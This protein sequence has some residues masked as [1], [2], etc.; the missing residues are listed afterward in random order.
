MPK[1]AAATA[2]LITLDAPRPIDEIGGASERQAFHKRRSLSVPRLMLGEWLHIFPDGLSLLHCLLYPQIAGTSRQANLSHRL[3][4]AATERIHSVLR[5]M[6]LA[7]SSGS[8][9][10]LAAHKHVPWLSHLSVISCPLSFT[11]FLSR[12]LFFFCFSLATFT[13]I[14]LTICL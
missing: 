11:V 8:V 9:R 13:S 12:N 4:G 10:V 6:P 1:G 14:W 3:T 5:R 2:Y 7:A